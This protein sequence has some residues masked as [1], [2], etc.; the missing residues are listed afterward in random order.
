MPLV[1]YV[2]SDGQEHE[3]ELPEGWTLMQGAT[4]NGIEEIEGECGGTMGCA[5]CHVYVD[6]AFLDRLDP[7]SDVE[8]AM[9]DTAAAAREHNSRLSCQ[10]KATELTDG[11][12][13][14]LPDTQY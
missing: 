13:V 11:I 10:I 1:T 7:V 12:I 5:T 3:I 14:R 8:S 4:M 2:E 9:L 6:D